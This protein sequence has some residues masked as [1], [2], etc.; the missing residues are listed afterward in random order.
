MP[1]EPLKFDGIEAKIHVSGRSDY[2]SF[3]AKSDVL[4]NRKLDHHPFLVFVTSGNIVAVAIVKNAVDLLNYSDDAPVMA[5]WPGEF[6]SDFFKF[7]VG[8]L[9]EWVQNNPPPPGSDRLV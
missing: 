2:A 3:F 5:Q 9:R 4:S 7:T 8:Q 1:E 6:R